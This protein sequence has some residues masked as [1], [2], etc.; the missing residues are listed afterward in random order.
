M[1]LEE[2]QDKET[3]KE[4]QRE[5]VRKGK[6]SGIKAINFHERTHTMSTFKVNNHYL[7]QHSRQV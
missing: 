2:G 5:K 7:Q 3:K 1:V 4:M 6:G